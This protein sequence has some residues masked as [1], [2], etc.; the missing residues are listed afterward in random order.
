[1]T[2]LVYN[3]KRQILLTSSSDGLALPTQIIPSS[4][5]QWLEISPNVHAAF[6]NQDHCPENHSWCELRQ[7]GASLPDGQRQLAAKGIELLE[8][9]AN[10]SFC[11]RCGSKTHRQT[12]ISRKCNNCSQEFFAPVS[13]AVLVL[14]RKDD[15]ALLVHAKNF[16]QPFYGLVAGFVETGE[17]LEECVRREVREE[18]SLEILNIRYFGSQPWPFPAQLMIGFTADWKSGEINLAD[19]ELTDAKFFSSNNL[20]MLPTPPSLARKMIDHFFNLTTQS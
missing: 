4:P 15:T 11:P 9:H 3:N 6:C 10:S 20:P 7:A 14:I 1:M 19:N 8:W 12:P 17:S 13:A 2:F 5:I 18:T 16:S